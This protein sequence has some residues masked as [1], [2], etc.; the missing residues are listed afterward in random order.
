MKHPPFVITRKAVTDLEGIWLYT[1][2]N[3]SVEQADRYYNLIID[4]INFTCKNPKAGR[5]MEHV[6]AGYLVAKVKSHLIFYRIVNGT[7]EVVRILHERMD[8]EGRL[9]E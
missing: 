3:W 5:S 9:E 8:V 2:Q 6:R 1:A 7:I 4:E